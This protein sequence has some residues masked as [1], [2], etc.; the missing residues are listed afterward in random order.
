VQREFN[1]RMK[2]R[3]QQEGIEIASPGQTILMQVPVEPDTEVK[4]VADSGAKPPRQL[5]AGRAT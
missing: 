3:F 5:T 2:L 1:R 4:T